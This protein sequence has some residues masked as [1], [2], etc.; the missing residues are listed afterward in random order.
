MTL[1]AAENLLDPEETAAPL[2]ILA[3]DLMD[4]LD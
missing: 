3:H 1:E 2:V 4:A